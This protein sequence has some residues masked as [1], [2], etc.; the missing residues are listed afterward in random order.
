MG[1]FLPSLSHRKEIISGEVKFLADEEGFEPPEPL[2]STVF[3]TAAI[4]HSATHPVREPEMDGNSSF[5]KTKMQF[6]LE[7]IERLRFKENLT[8]KTAAR[9]ANLWLTMFTIHSSEVWHIS[10][11]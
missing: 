8:V 3:K 6:F 5:G 11:T 7:D 10:N 2:G 4:D 1:P 9:S